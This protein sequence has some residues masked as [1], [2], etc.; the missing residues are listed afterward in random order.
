M[1]LLRYVYSVVGVFFYFIFSSDFFPLH[2]SLSSV[3]C[4]SENF[5]A[6]TFAMLPFDAHSLI[7]FSLAGWLASTIYYQ[8]YSW[9]N[10]SHG[11]FI[12]TVELGT[13]TATLVGIRN[14]LNVAFRDSMIFNFPLSLFEFKAQQFHLQF[15]PFLNEFDGIFFF[16]CLK[17]SFN[18]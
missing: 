6:F 5:F 15:I 18:N 8:I 12:A 16:F 9:T 1:L 14:Q 4:P 10:I 3:D 7:L 13:R 11:N 17:C 2:R